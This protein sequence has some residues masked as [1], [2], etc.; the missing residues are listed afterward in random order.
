ALRSNDD[1]NC[2]GHGEEN[3]KS[4]NVDS[5]VGGHQQPLLDTC[6][7]PPAKEDPEGDQ[8]EAEDEDD[9]NQN[10]DDYADVRIVGVASELDRQ[11]K[12]PGEAGGGHER[13]TQK[14]APLTSHQH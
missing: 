8:H 14:S 3:R 1:V 2:G 7:A 13:D 11:N 9:W 6:D 12:K 10:K 4:P 5:P